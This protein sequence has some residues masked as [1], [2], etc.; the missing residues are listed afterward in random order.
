MGANESSLGSSPESGSTVKPNALPTSTTGPATT[1]E[2]RQRQKSI[3]PASFTE[4]PGLKSEPWQIRPG[5][6]ATTATKP[7]MIQT[8]QQ[9]QSQLQLESPVCGTPIQASYFSAGVT[10]SQSL[11]S[12]SQVPPSITE[13]GDPVNAA[14]Q[15]Q[16]ARATVPM[17]ITWH[18]GGKEVSVLMSGYNHDQPL[19]MSRSKHD[20][21]LVLDLPPGTH[22]FNFIV[23]GKSRCSNEFD[24]LLDQSGN[25]V[26]YVEVQSIQT[27]Q[28]VLDWLGESATLHD[29]SESA[30]EYHQQ[31][32][33]YLANSRN[34]SLSGSSFGTPSDSYLRSLHDTSGSQPTATQKQPPTLPSML[35]KTVLNAPPETPL[36]GN[37]RMMEELPI[38]NQVTINHLFALSIKDGVMGLATTKRYRKKYTTVILYRPVV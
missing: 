20:F 21:Q 10:P 9:H 34:Q 8:F 22:R 30:E 1:S 15:S 11:S 5:Q 6:A 35:D 4:L 27:E 37:N 31:V 23:D 38:P 26:N 36:L 24:T 25:M 3:D 33:A 13:E 17:I 32:P 19:R 29:G 2:Q 18:G 28:D 16:N 14:I 7:N 12:R